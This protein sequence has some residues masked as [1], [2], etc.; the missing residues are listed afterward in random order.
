M[1][2]G[3]NI[4]YQSLMDSTGY[5][6]PFAK[7]FHKINR[8]LNP[9]TSKVLIEII[10]C[11]EIPGARQ[12]GKTLC[13]DPKTVWKTLDELAHYRILIKG[14]KRK[15]SWNTKR[16]DWVKCENLLQKTEQ[17]KKPRKK[18]ISKSAPKNGADLLQKTEQISDNLLHQK[19][20]IAA[21]SLL[22]KKNIKKNIKKEKLKKTDLAL[23]CRD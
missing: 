1:N 7:E 13:M 17:I 23:G 19:E 6:N 5:Y 9:A 4:A 12:L 2:Y 3:T 18:R 10:H 14:L 21:L 8:I 22:L 11:Q 15:Y 16:E 20:Q